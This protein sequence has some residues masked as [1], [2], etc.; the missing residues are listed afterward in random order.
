MKLI[1]ES[2]FL[3]LRDDVVDCIAFEAGMI[4]FL[5]TAMRVNLNLSGK[6]PHTSSSAPTILFYKKNSHHRSRTLKL[7]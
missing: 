7:I 2:F 4:A 1:R 5:A 6:L 3:A